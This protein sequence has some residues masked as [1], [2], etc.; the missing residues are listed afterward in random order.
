[1]VKGLKRTEV[2]AY[3]SI[4]DAGF[5]LRADSLVNINSSPTKTS[6]YL[7]AGMM[8]V[9]T[10]FAGDAPMQIDESGCGVVFPGLD[11]T[12]DDIRRLDTSLVD[13]A[14]NYAEMSAKAKEYVFKNRVWASNEKKLAS[15][16][17]TLESGN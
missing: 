9:A 13:Y 1:M 2:P 15:L 6:E 10:R 3:L 16:Y 8:V 11:F 14:E 17:A 5:V 7:A 4:A 12:D